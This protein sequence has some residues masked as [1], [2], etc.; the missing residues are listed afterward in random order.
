MFKNG[1]VLGENYK[2]H[3]EAKNVARAEKKID[4]TQA[5]EESCHIITMDVQSC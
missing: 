5:L 1:N 3:I 4:K 2:R